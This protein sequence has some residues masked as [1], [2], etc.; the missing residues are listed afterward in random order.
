MCLIAAGIDVFGR[1]IKYHRPRGP[2]CLSGHCSGCLMR[3]DG[4]PNQRSC[5]IHCRS[6]MLV[7]RQSGWPG[8]GFDMLRAVD[9][10]SGERLDHHSMF[11]SSSTMN[12][13]AARIVRRFSGYGDPPSADPPA[14]VPMRKQD[15]KTV[16]IGAGAAGLSAALALAS[17]GH[18]LLLF[19][20]S[21]RVGGR[22]LD[23]ATSISEPGG[24][25]DDQIESGWSC[26]Q[27]IEKRL[28]DSSGIETHTGTGVLA[29]Y[30]GER[31]EVL[32]SNLEQT[33]L[34]RAERLIICS[35]AYE[36]L[37]LFANNDLPGLF[38]IRALDRLV[39][40]YGVVPGEPL[41]V[42]GDSERALRLADLLAENDLTLSGVVTKRR[43]GEAIDRL[44]ARGVPV[45]FDYK[46]TGARGGRRLD[47]IE[48]APAG[49]LEA[50]LIL[51]CRACAI[52]APAAPAYELAYHAGCRVG[53]ASDSGYQVTTE[54]DGMTSH[55][56]I[57]AAGHCT[58]SRST[59]EALLHGEQAGRACA[60]SIREEES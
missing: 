6:G 29:V 3:I 40:G 17:A 14:A 25:A 56:N 13:L 38:G 45:F 47:R 2:W 19:E 37:P 54:G 1:S 49:G 41:V 33:F 18:E 20:S 7:E 51:D 50:D 5:E 23:A 10:L 42:V 11:T 34:V 16:I 9:W 48:L 32:A 31:F 24:R 15:A 30:P 22:L 44:R 46:P 58:G 60:L 59:E 43:E 57:F 35:G 21:R 28:A 39:C 53:F 8:T 36:Q 55:G 27:K 26:L 12:R 52:E 4:I